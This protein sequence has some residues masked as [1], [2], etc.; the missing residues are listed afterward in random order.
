ML[1]EKMIV[2]IPS[3][4][5]FPYQP[6][7]FIYGKIKEF[8]E[9]G[10]EVKIEIYDPLKLANFYQDYL[11][12][13]RTFPVKMVI[14]A[15][16]KLNSM[17]L[18]HGI[19]MKVIAVSI[20]KGDYSIYYL[21]NP[22]TLSVEKVSED[23]IFPSFEGGEVSPLVQLRNMEFKNPV[24]Y[25]GRSVVLKT[26]SRL[27]Y[28]LYGL[29]ELAGSKIKL[30]AHQLETVIK[31]L[32]APKI[33]FMLADEVGMGKSIEALAILKI[34]LSDHVNKKCLLVVPKALLEQWKLEMETKFNLSLIPDHRNNLIEI[35]AY[36]DLPPSYCF[37]NWDFIIMDEIHRL[38]RSSKFQ[39]INRLS[40]YSE[41]ILLLSATPIRERGDEYQKLI[42]LIDPKRFDSL[43][44][45]QFKKLIGRENKI[46]SIAVDILDDVDELKALL[47][48]SDYDQDEA[49]D[50]LEEIEECFSD[51]QKIVNDPV[52]ENLFTEIDFHL[53]EANLTKIETAITYITANYQFG[54]CIIRNRKNSFI[55]RS[56]DDQYHGN[57]DEINRELLSIPYSFDSV[58]SP[59]E[60]DVWEELMGWVSTQFISTLFVENILINL[61]QAFFSSC[62]AFKST[63]FSLEE[64]Y[65]LQLPETLL[66]K[67]ENWNNY[68][69]LVIDK[70][71]FILEDPDSF[72][73][74]VNNRL[75][76]ILNY[77]FD[78]T[79]GKTVLITSFDNTFNLYNEALASVFSESEFSVFSARNTSEEN[80][81]SV[82]RFQ[83]DNKCSILLCDYSG[84]E[85]RNFQIADNLVFIDLPWNCSDIEQRIGR[86]DRIDR[87]P[88]R[89]TVTSVVPYAVNSIESQIF[90]LWNSG[91]NLFQKSM[92]GMEI[93]MEDV[94][95]QIVNG[96]AED[97]Q[98]G[99]LSKKEFL[100]DLVKSTEHE[101]RKE[102]FINRSANGY[103]RLHQKVQ[104]SINEFNEDGGLTLQDA[105]TSWAA[106][107]GFHGRR[108]GDNLIQY[109]PYSFSPKSAANTFL[110]P[111]NWDHYLNKRN[112]LEKVISGRIIQDRSILGTFSRSI[113]VKSDYIHFFAPEDDIFDC[114]TNNAIQSDRGQ[115]T[116]VQIQS[117]INWIGFVFTFE[118]VPDVRILLDSNIPLRKVGPYQQYFY[119]SLVQVPVS[120]EKN[121]MELDETVLRRFN[122]WLKSRN[123]KTKCKY[124][125]SRSKK[126]ILEDGTQISRITCL[127]E[128]YPG[129][130]W[131]ESVNE[132]FREALKKVRNDLQNSHSVKEMKEEI[133]KS[134]MLESV[135]KT[136]FGI[137][138]NYQ[139]LKNEYSIIFKA[140]N[141]PK[142]NLVSAAY[143]EMVESQNEPEFD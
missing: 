120:I 68:E 93:L 62:R 27:N 71:P 8:N 10:D 21:Q 127:K 132:A 76:S 72:L 37:Q 113:A 70:L 61:Y 111:P 36:E 124:L 20:V 138:N 7:K 140:L 86:L 141:H 69:N 25:Q 2:R 128:K 34:Y 85:G 6:R 103:L 64:R 53:S 118:L 119:K 125:G 122:I 100:I 91:M 66:L 13:L 17:L 121:S 31:C 83:N 133:N 65:E 3:D 109:S 101:L 73:D 131:I 49:A 16:L 82:W 45:D 60:Y 92:S 11:T 117:E 77:L 14:R 90:D 51:L 78:E 67:V 106:L 32:S 52:F 110:I 23:R 48:Q 116:A 54:N 134:M 40:R 50:Y 55:I 47:D 58:S 87:D 30:L 43:T 74:L 63:L 94:D 143:I 107:S 114:I 22:K 35:C 57:F 33:R 42:E 38:I 139:A 98:S 115:S 4:V 105:L 28:S 108:V 96:L 102:K 1:K 79:E 29:K 126:V 26:M 12:P 89:L 136:F 80:E 15:Q 5:E 129:D 41:N 46:N 19:M 97:Y 123:I 135:Q 137:N 59:E 24:W 44:D 142:I 56:E 99:L 75:F 112:N 130:E 9:F 95:Q 84:G 88:E 81:K 18:Y 104:S 39:L